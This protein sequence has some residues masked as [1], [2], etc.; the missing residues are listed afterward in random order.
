[1]KIFTDYLFKIISTVTFFLLL[2]ACSDFPKDPRNSLENAK[3]T[4][5]KVGVALNQSFT[6]FEDS[7]LSGSEIDLIR[8]FARRNNLDVNFTIASESELIS[9]LEK[10]DLHIAAGGFSKKT[11]WSRKVGTTLA[12]DGSHVLLI[13]KGENALVTELERHFL[14]ETAGK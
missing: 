13:P 2:N 7:V 5:L 4:G 3:A 14:K 6:I 9:K 10:Y 8:E 1:M 11:I 12:Y